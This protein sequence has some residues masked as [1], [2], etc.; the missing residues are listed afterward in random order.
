MWLYLVLVVGLALVLDLDTGWLI[1][2]H[3]CLRYVRLSF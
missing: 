3:M 1:V 2:M